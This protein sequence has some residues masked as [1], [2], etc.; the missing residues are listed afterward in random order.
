MI[1]QGDPKC[2]GLAASLAV[3]AGEKME[4]F[5]MWRPYRPTTIKIRSGDFRT[6]YKALR[7]SSSSF[8]HRSDVKR[9]VY[10]KYSG[11]CYLCGAVND[12]QIDHI[13]SVYR[14]A[15]EQIEPVSGLNKLDNLA[16]ICRRCNSGKAL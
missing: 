10:E 15:L 11:R 12:L 8:T 6:R 7:D 16:L 9:I 5:P 4:E 13:V 2:Q 1:M 3:K 14:Y